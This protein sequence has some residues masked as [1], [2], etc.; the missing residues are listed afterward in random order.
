[1]SYQKLSLPNKTCVVRN[2]MRTVM[3]MENK[4]EREP[5][6]G[7]IGPRNLDRSRHDNF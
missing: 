2:D 6:A 7:P 3:T 5:I 1:M 4:K